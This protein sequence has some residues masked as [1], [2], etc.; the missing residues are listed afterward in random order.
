MTIKQGTTLS[1][2][3]L[4]STRRGV[5]DSDLI[6]SWDSWQKLISPKCSKPSEISI[7]SAGLN[8]QLKI[9][10]GSF[11]KT[12]ASRSRLLKPTRT[13]RFQTVKVWKSSYRRANQTA[14]WAFPRFPMALVTQSAQT[15]ITKHWKILW[16][17]EQNKE[18]REQWSASSCASAV[19]HY[20]LTTKTSVGTLCK[21]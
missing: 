11:Q 6:T 18:G 9:A 17:E 21:N 5:L 13:A 20:Y 1:R 12:K 15:Q 16:S 2:G 14:K 10:K 8:T 3:T 19:T 4:Y 7:S